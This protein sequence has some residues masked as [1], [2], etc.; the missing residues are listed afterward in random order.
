MN[1]NNPPPRGSMSCLQ[2]YAL[3]TYDYLVENMGTPR[4]AACSK[5]TVEW[6]MTTFDVYDWKQEGTPKGL[7]YW[8]I[9]GESLQA[10][11]DFEDITGIPTVSWLERHNQK[12]RLH[13]VKS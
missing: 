4:K 8:Q 13:Q 10:L 2:G 5:S 11:K 1:L 9:G 12:V 7:Y 6:D 3:T